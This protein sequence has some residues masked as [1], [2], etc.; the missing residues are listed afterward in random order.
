MCEIDPVP[1]FAPHYST[2][3]HRQPSFGRF[4]PLSRSFRPPV[5]FNAQHPTG[6]HAGRRAWNDGPR[7]AWWGAGGGENQGRWWKR[8]QK[9]G[10]L[11]RRLG[12]YV[13]DTSYG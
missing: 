1:H 12:R 6:P 7:G 9:V 3:L 4:A 13:A 11:R 2:S 8:E 10:N 5:P